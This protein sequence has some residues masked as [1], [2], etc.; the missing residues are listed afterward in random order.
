MEDAHGRPARRPGTPLTPHE[1]ALL[2]LICAGTWRG[3]DEARAQ[4]VHAR[5]GG[6]DHSGDACFLIDVP[7]RVDTPRIP[8]HAGGPIA[9]LDVTDGDKPF[10]LLELWVEDGRL[11]SLD[12]SIFS[13]TAGEGLPELHQIDGTIASGGT[14]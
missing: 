4:L 9:T 14:E 13:D 5:W 2:E 3:A 10:G 6:K 7:A 1:T 12:Y 8:S 11:H